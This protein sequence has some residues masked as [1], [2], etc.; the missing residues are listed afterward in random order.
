MNVACSVKT[1]LHETKFIIKTKES[2]I[3]QPVTLLLHLRP[4]ARNKEDDV[5]VSDIDKNLQGPKHAPVCHVK[6][7]VFSVEQ[8]F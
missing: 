8:V 2:W 4:H 6:R 1:C 5:I 3:Y 7:L